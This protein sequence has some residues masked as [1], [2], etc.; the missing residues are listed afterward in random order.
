MGA[1]G[2]GAASTSGVAA[3]LWLWMWPAVKASGVRPSDVQPRLVA[4]VGDGW[5]VLVV[6]PA[7]SQVKI[8]DLPR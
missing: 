7:I 5:L 8:D 3:A 4:L 1:T 6:E 2:A